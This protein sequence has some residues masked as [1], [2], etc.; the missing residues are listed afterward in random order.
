MEP[1]VKRSNRLDQIDTELFEQMLA[2]GSYQLLR[3][4]IAG[5]LERARTDCENQPEP[6][7]VYKAQ[8][9]VRALRV[10][11]ELPARILQEMKAGTRSVD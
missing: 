2:S 1:P 11:L 6:R 8:G 10:A 3:A 9:A 7:E 5:E 4:R